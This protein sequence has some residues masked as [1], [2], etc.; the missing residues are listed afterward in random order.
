MS[1]RGVTTGGILSEVAYKQPTHKY[2]AQEAIRLLDGQECERTSL[3]P[4]QHFGEQMAQGAYDEDSG[5]NW[6]RHFSDPVTGRSLTPGRYDSALQRAQ[7]L[8]TAATAEYRGQTATKSWTLVG[9][10]S[11][12]IQD[13]TVPAHVQID[14]HTPLDPRQL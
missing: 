3:G 13:M 5:V 6:L 12:L 2:A 10:I 8:W 4:G 1:V 9:Q 14:E 11:H 7:K